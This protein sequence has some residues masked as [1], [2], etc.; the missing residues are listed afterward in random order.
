MAETTAARV[1]QRARE[2]EPGVV[3]L[4]AGL[5]LA[6]YLQGAFFPKVQLLVA[7]P[8]VIGALLAPRLPAITRADL[9]I[10]LIGGGLALWAIADGLLTGHSVAG[11]RYFL[12]I[13]GMLGLVVVCRQ[14]LASARLM[15]VAGLLVVCSAVAA[16][17]WLG[18]VVHLGN[19]GFASDDLW[20]ASSSL[21]YPNA[22]AAVLAMA[23]LA[24]LALRCGDPVSRWLGGT[25]TLLLTGL[26]ATLSRAGL[27]GLVVGLV[28]LGFGVGWRLL[29]RAS[30]GPVLGALVA[31]AGLVPAITSHSVTVVTAL[32][33]GLALVVGLVVGCRVAASRL[34]LVVLV[35]VLAA[36][37][38]LLALRLASRFTFNSPDRWGSFH[39]AWDLFLGHPVAGVGPGIDRLV[40]ARAAGGISVFRFA[41]NEYLQV[42]A[43]L[44]VVG[45][46]LLVAFLVLVVRWLWHERAVAIGGLS[47]LAALLVQS[48]FDFVWHIPAVPLL[49]AALVGAAMA[50]PDASTQHREENA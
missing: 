40:L 8:L 50:R 45:G 41:H 15:L 26:V 20:R 11:L 35:V 25:S 44:G 30:V 38:V 37:L 1:I 10:L 27:G 3:L 31:V 18:V 28:L 2:I 19:W 46:V 22:T 21:T 42:L 4:V 43:E 14:L 6:L 32:V 34:V 36:A 16:F 49:A 17:G 13:F 47:V 24:C 33:A 39:A 5:A 7:V 29:V 23:S 9:P 12:L 48:G